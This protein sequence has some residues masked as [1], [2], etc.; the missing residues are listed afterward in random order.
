MK[1]HLPPTLRASILTCM[2]AVAGMF[3]T[4]ATGTAFIGT[5]VLT[6]AVSTAHADWAPA[7]ITYTGTIVVDA[8]AT[9][10][11]TLA[12]NSTLTYT[13]AGNGGPIS[14]PELNIKLIANEAAAGTGTQIN[15]Q[16]N[17][18]TAGS[19]W[20][21]QGRFTVSSATV[22]HAGTLYA[23]GG[24]LFVTGNIGNAIMLGSSTYTENDALSGAA[25][26]IEQGNTVS[27][28]ITLVEDAAITVFSGTASISGAIVTGGYTLEKKGNGLLQFSAQQTRTFDALVLNGGTLRS[29]SNGNNIAVSA[30]SLDVKSN[31]TLAHTN[32][33]SVWTI[34]DLSSSAADSSSIT[35]TLDNQGTHYFRQKF[36]F[37]GTT[38]LDE[39]S[40]FDGTIDVKDTGAKNNGNWQIE[41][42]AG[43]ATQLAH[44]VVNL[45]N[46]AILAVTA[47]SVELEGL[48]S[49][50]TNAYVFSGANGSTAQTNGTN[51]GAT[52]LYTADG[53]IRTLTLS[54]NGD[55]SFTGTI[56]GNLIVNK[57]GGGLQT[58]GN[59]GDNVTIN[60]NAGSL[61]LKGTVGNNTAINTVAG[62]TVTVPWELTNDGNIYTAT[63]HV[64]G[65]VTGDG[66]IFTNV[67]AAVGNTSFSTD[68][69]K[70]TKLVVGD[71]GDESVTI[72]SGLVSLITGNTDSPGTIA[73]FE[74]ISTFILDGGGFILPTSANQEFIF[75]KNIEVRGD[76]YLR[77]WGDG[78]TTALLKLTGDITGSGKLTK[79]DGGTITLAGD[80]SGFTGSVVIG[81]GSLVFDTDAT[82]SSLD[83]N[84]NST[85][86]VIG[87]HRVSVA[88]S[89]DNPLVPKAGTYTFNVEDGSDFSTSRIKFTNATTLN[90][91]SSTH[92]S[93]TVQGM[94]MADTGN[95]VLTI[96]ANTAL[97]VMGTN[98]AKG[99]SGNNFNKNTTFLLAHYSGDSH[100]NVN[101]ALNMLSCGAFGLT[102]RA[103]TM[104]V[105]DGGE[106]N[107]LGL[108]VVRR[109][110]FVAS[111]KKF[112]LTFESGSSLHIGS[113][114]IGNAT[115]DYANSSLVLVF[116]GGTIGILSSTTGWS[117]TRELTL[118]GDVVV[119]TRLYTAATDGTAGSYENTGGT[120]TLTGAVTGDGRLIKKGVGTLNLA[121]VD[122]LDVQ[123]GFVGM[124][125]LLTITDL[126]AMTVGGGR[127]LVDLGTDQIVSASYAGQL[128]LSA[129]ASTAGTF[130]VFSGD[131]NL[132]KDNIDFNIYLDRGLTFDADSG[133]TVNGGQV[134]VTV[135]GTATTERFDLVWAGDAGE[136]WSNSTVQAWTGADDQRF[137][138]GD[139]V[140]F[141]GGGTKE[142]VIE[143][144]VTPGAVTVTGDADYTF[145]GG[146]I[147]GES[148]LTKN[149]TGVLTI[150]TDLSEWTGNID[151]GG[152]TI[153]FAGTLGTGTINVSGTSE[154]AWLKGNATDLS[155]RLKIAANADVTF[156]IA[157]G[158]TVI[159]GSALSPLNTGE[160][161]TFTKA[162]QGTLQLTNNK[163]LYGNVVVAEGTLAIKGGSDP[164]G[165]IA[166]DVTVKSGA[167]ILVERGNFTG[168]YPGTNITK[169]L[170][171]E[172]AEII[173]GANSTANTHSLP[174]N[175][176]TMMGATIRSTVEGNSFELTE[177]SVVTIG[178]TKLSTIE[179][180][181]ILDNGNST[182]GTIFNVADAVAGDGVDLIVKGG[183]S[184]HR[185]NTS[186]TKRGE[187]TME[188][189]GNYAAGKLRLEAGAMIL[190]DGTL[191]DDAL[192]MADGT[193]LQI[194]KGG[195]V[196]WSLNGDRSIDQ[197][198]INLAEGATLRTTSTQKH[199]LTL[200]AGNTL[201]G[202][203]T[204]I[205]GIPTTAGQTDG[206][207]R[208]ITING[209]TAGF[210]GIV[211]LEASEGATG[212]YRGSLTLNSS[213]GIFGGVIRTQGVLYGT[214]TV[215]MSGVV[216][217]MAL[218]TVQK[219]MRIGGFEGTG[220]KLV[221]DVAAGSRVTLTVG[222]ESDHSF[223]GSVGDKIDLVKTG[224]GKQ[225]FDGDLSAFDGSVTVEEGVLDMGSL[226][227]AKSLS[228]TGTG[229]GFATTG[230]VSV[231]A[232]QT[233]A[234]TATGTVVNAHLDIAGGNVHLGD[235]TTESHAVGLGGH[236]LS[237]SATDKTNL[238]LTLPGDLAAGST[239]DLFTDV[240]GLLSGG[241]ALT[242]GADALL[243]TYF[244][245]GDIAA[246][247]N[248]KLQLAGGKL[249]IVLA[250]G[251]N[252]LVYGLGD[253]G[254]WRTDAAFDAQGS[255]FTADA[256]VEFGAIADGDSMTVK[257]GDNISAGSVSIEAGEGKTYRFVQNEEGD[258]LVGSLAAFGGMTIGKGTVDFAADTL[259]PGADATIAVNGGTLSLQ[260]GATNEHVFLRLG[261]G[262]TLRWGSG[263]TT[264]YSA[265][266]RLTI[267]DRAHVT[268]DTNGNR[269]V[270]GVNPGS[271]VNGTT[272]NVTLAG[273]GRLVL[274]D[275][276]VLHGTV[277]LGDQ[278][279]RMNASDAAY[280]LKVTGNGTLIARGKVILTGASDFAGELHIGDNSDADGKNGSEANAANA[281]LTATDT[282]LSAN[283]TAIKLI[284]AADGTGS[285]FNFNAAA[286]ATILAPITGT[287]NV[288]FSGGHEITLEGANSYAGKTSIGADTTLKVTDATLS[289]HTEIGAAGETGGTLE[290]TN[291]QTSAPLEFANKVSESVSVTVSAGTFQWLTDAGHE[292][293]YTGTTTVAANT[294]IAAAGPLTTGAN[295]KIV[296]ADATSTLRLTLT[297]EPDAWT[298]GHTVS[299]AGTLEIATNGA[300]IGAGGTLLQNIID[301][302]DAAGT[303]GVMRLL[304]GTAFEITSSA[305]AQTSVLGKINTIDVQSGA[306]LDMRAPSGAAAQN[307]TIAGA[308]LASAEEGEATASALRLGNGS[309]PTFTLSRTVTL[310]D[311]ATVYVDA[312]KTGV[313][314]ETLTNDGHVLTKTGAGT[315][316]FQKTAADDSYA[317][318]VKA[319]TLQY[320][321]NAGN[322]FGPITLSAGT[323]LS[324][325][326]TANN[327]NRQTIEHLTLDGDATLQ[328]TNFAGAWIVSSLTGSH[329]L[330]IDGASS[331]SENQYAVVNG[332]SFSGVV[333]VKQSQATAN[334]QRGVVF[335]LNSADALQSATIN[336]AEATTANAGILH[337]LVFAVGGD[338]D[339]TI[340]IGALQGIAG[341]EIISS[342][343][344]V[345]D[346]NGTLEDGNART[347]DITG[348]TNQTF[349]GSV[350]ANLTVRMSGTGEQT[351]SGALADGTAFVAQAGALKI[352]SQ[353]QTGSHLFR[354]EGGRLDMSGYARAADAAGT[355]SIVYS[356]GSIDNL[357]LASGMELGAADNFTGSV[358]LGGNTVLD[359]GSL[360]FRL[361]NNAGAYQDL[362]TSY[363]VQSGGSISVG[364]SG[365]TTMLTF[366]PVD[367]KLD[368]TDSAT[369]KDYVLISN[370]GETFGSGTV[371]LDA[372]HLDFNMSTAGR[373]KYTLKV[374]E[375]ADGT[376]DLVLNVFGSA[377]DLT[378]NGSSSA[379]NTA[380]DNA[381]WNNGTADTAFLD[382][383]YV[384]FGTLA[385]A[386]TVTVD[387]AGVRMGGM[388][389]VGSTDYTFEGG[390]ITSSAGNKYATLTIGTVDDE[391]EGTTG[392]E[393]TGTLTI[394]TANSYA[395]GTTI[396]SGTVI[397]GNAA[398]LSNTALVVNGGSLNLNFEGTLGTS[399][400]TMNGGELNALLDASVA[401]LTMAGADTA[402]ALGA[403]A[404]KTL[405]LATANGTIEGALTIGSDTMTGTVR[406]D[407]GTRSLATAQTIDVQGGELLL[408][409]TTGSFNG[410]TVALNGGDLRV[411]GG[412]SATLAG[413]SGTG[414][415]AIVE[416]STLTFSTAADIATQID[417]H[418]ATIAATGNLTLGNLRLVAGTTTL[419]GT[420]AL[421][422]ATETAGT[423]LAVGKTGAAG[424][425]TL[426]AGVTSLDDV[427]I[428][429]GSLTVKNGD[430]LTFLESRGTLTTAADAASLTL[431]SAWLKDGSG[432]DSKIT[433]TFAG[434]DALAGDKAT[435]WLGDTEAGAKTTL[436]DVIVDS[437]S[438][439]NLAGHVELASLRIDRGTVGI[440]SNIAK[441]ENGITLAGTDAALNMRNLNPNATVTLQQGSLSNAGNYAGTV[442]IDDTSTGTA[443][444]MGGLTDKATVTL[445]QFAEGS[446]LTGLGSLKLGDSTIRL[447]DGMQPL[448][449]M[450]DPAAGTVGIADGSTVSI[451]CGAILNDVL[452]NGTGSYTVT[453]GSLGGLVDGTTF[454]NGVVFDPTL[455][456]YN[457]A[458]SIDGGN[459]VFNV[460]DPD[461]NAD[462]VYKSTDDGTA[463]DSYAAMDSIAKVDIDTDTTIDLTG[464]TIPAEQT[465][466]GLIIK[467]LH[468]TGAA[469]TTLAIRGNAD[470][471]VTFNNNL[472]STWYNGSVTVDTA[473]LQIR[474]TDALGDGSDPS[475]RE[476]TIL[477]SLTSTGM[478]TVTDGKLTLAGNGNS[479]DGGLTLN[480]DADA[481]EKGLLTINGHTSLG[482]TVLGGD[483]TTADIAVGNGAVVTLKDGASLQAWISGSNAETLAVAEN[484]QTTFASTARVEGLGLRLDKNATATIRTTG[485]ALSFQGLT[486]TGNLVGDADAQFNLALQ[487]TTT[488]VFGGDLSGYK[489]LITV[490]GEGSQTFTTAAEQTSFAVRGGN[491]TF[492]N[493]DTREDAVHSYGDTTLQ[494]GSLHFDTR[495]AGTDGVLTN[496]TIRLTSLTTVAPIR[497][498]AAGSNTLVFDM[499]LSNDLQGAGSSLVTVTGDNAHI[500]KGTVIDVNIHGIASD[501]AFKPGET[502]SFTLL[503]GLDGNLTDASDLQFKASKSL[504]EKYFGDI[505]LTID[506]NK[507]QLTGTTVTANEV[508]YHQD[509]ATTETGRAGGALLDYLYITA[510]PQG[511]APGSL[512]ASVLDSL[513]DIIDNGGNA[514][515]AMAG[516]A[517][518]T[519]TTLSSA[520]ASGLENQITSI[521]N[522]MT[523]M[524]VD[525]TL[526]N[527]DMPYFHAWISAN[528]G[529]TRL[530]ADG[531]LAG[532]KLNSWGGTV[533]VDVDVNEYLTMGAAFTAS[534]GDLTTDGAESGDGHLDTYTAALFAHARV[535]RWTHDLV[536]AVSTADADLDRT[537][538]YGAGSYK[539][540]GSTNGIGFGA[541]YEAAY[542]I[543]VGEDGSNLLQ[544][545][546]RASF[547]HVSVDGY[548]ETKAE[549]MG[550]AVGKQDITY[551]TFGLGARYIASIGENVFNR[552]AT[553]ELRALA[554]QDAGSRRGEADVALGGATGRVRTVRG[555]KP[556]STGLQA[557]AGLNVPIQETS[558]IFADFSVDVRKKA[559]SVSGSIG[560]R[561]DF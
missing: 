519:V 125:G 317:F 486:G 371:D 151:L 481:G 85:L 188:I 44:T 285:T 281:T 299:G 275:G 451:V 379:W 473:G 434:S 91:T 25:L 510:N 267:D 322:T 277:D 46:Y 279:L 289:A 102:D 262:S 518:S 241:T 339:G 394:N 347:L 118:A 226:N 265:G 312:S 366:I 73:D 36:I 61:V 15:F 208:N 297:G 114:G 80:M 485:D 503:E 345:R 286:N 382:E 223:S 489:G 147:A 331:A 469:E 222:R 149:G 203:G 212:A 98:M 431:G 377:A 430:S 48:T 344:I 84:N 256:N 399:G 169:L 351:L 138:T 171:E 318:A 177:Q 338:A 546:V 242:L 560:Y 480:D 552:T 39:A 82:L 74:S 302:T 427:T 278:E 381:A 538:D 323:T 89:A 557:G 330:T 284:A 357:R 154:L 445:K 442:V 65:Y 181:L 437:A 192:S 209:S 220:G 70:Y 404:D 178:G 390:S 360:S 214:P 2:A 47:D 180:D 218:I 413:L 358:Q 108:D 294:T 384:V 81:K 472:S 53:T 526:V 395:G 520:F 319:G 507:L 200:G 52:P 219:D 55:Y 3:T 175:A 27:G 348:A 86:G 259:L 466:D 251:T 449:V 325:Y 314:A 227:Y 4:V 405:T 287:G 506:G 206:D 113:G 186:L 22:E 250:R 539:T 196:S 131:I 58:L 301:R 460:L 146:A 216:P 54:G 374:T 350:G 527:E 162:G 349:A 190:H 167:K 316:V 369:G 537:V 111:A 238:S 479:L 531:S 363:A 110:D 233:L 499:N 130:V 49:T 389:V 551:A 482:G 329:A 483:G 498:D 291:T 59:I 95:S 76:G 511:T 282:S 99:Q 72:T 296:L 38:T 270:L 174:S 447:A 139:N 101:G 547:T 14:A 92:G 448:F 231:G 150:N 228:L 455:G 274:G 235:I 90:L 400:V 67:I 313:L 532:Y 335:Q 30:A 1:L 164:E 132:S 423:S 376:K 166:G 33:N 373:T 457:V 525:Q 119:D 425:V 417:A 244:N 255:A 327:D 530:D 407:I 116:N 75:D 396:N 310:A 383:D 500:A 364:D 155:S 418:N 68:D 495:A 487:E 32:W 406:F 140:T 273:G 534:Y 64:P 385:D 436:G 122:K 536:L 16:N 225:T 305:A 252:S 63:Y 352:S 443:F 416:N 257:L 412:L 135:G 210:T 337:R 56:A 248:A 106:L 10:A 165:S 380:T 31:S 397:A 283:V 133:L 83:M 555:A 158:D 117:T 303:L 230:K 426:G 153:A 332:G 334:A 245:F 79:T 558:A 401:N 258:A 471:K 105:A 549:S 268:F 148:L 243:S 459:V 7:D 411:A 115:A 528:G 553:L 71:Y 94:Q 191:A 120:I 324:F 96:G 468:N 463:I 365:G 561:I 276:S 128:N 142:I 263:N 524:G 354:A 157:E 247:D 372:Y 542:D 234:I 315:L 35:L 454:K 414:G 361:T 136:V 475:D 239:I 501:F 143:G 159:F 50:N 109:T 213:D 137:S 269:V 217:E 452:R 388:T 326:N 367:K 261:E 104:T 97:N 502:M 195:V 391:T 307:L 152:G 11:L 375:N 295:S 393:F 78:A 402:K 346:K 496:R 272:G 320:Q 336:L 207:G 341:S 23:Q 433:V 5:V 179:A 184:K 306:H 465:Q 478:V 45:S 415:K 450:N 173:L 24:Q 458:A 69:A 408:D 93:V 444:A 211:Q 51:N 545:L 386:Q 491:L 516:I 300:T 205:V 461:H 368:P 198:E 435:S 215:N 107:V 544:P 156:S 221:T 141:D 237:L 145:S 509:A 266:F 124:N 19:V 77:S 476:L 421:N 439:V 533:G 28:R 441:V 37:N 488:A 182:D 41:M 293:T 170:L 18:I 103:A 432:I 550:L 514:D 429:N 34:G 163:S 187:G 232:G 57:T 328:T 112:T 512:A 197:G 467:N 40:L 134:S 477:G 559:T 6:A 522:R 229:A 419:V 290:L 129:N 497:R 246:L 456:L 254:V 172:D 548:T 29:S 62:T 493:A 410:T 160:T 403:V 556:G 87:G 387:E 422:G 321:G 183:F 298:S 304:S 168:W 523:G 189:T 264:D 288:S 127:F 260:A 333:N 529:N 271:G 66:D 253:N 409:G 201:S 513:E 554:L 362:A 490:T 356:A 515:R 224:S 492:R 17:A 249:Q 308:G 505:S 123:E 199:K 470:D 240:S 60:L 378:W 185:G 484:A 353:E 359:G 462:A 236:Q 26:R 311:D 193:L 100:V 392:E 517:G 521:R 474:N 541:L 88:S 543:H 446:S 494:G 9:D 340:S 504:L 370:V 8:A 438:A 43:T 398:A 126:S 464:T 535:K 202:A 12:E 508:H 424:N 309:A 355:D 428:A 453:N 42:H 420:I 13:Y 21:S 121:S 161:A 144:I 292:K 440:Y 194:A 342:S 540:N 176:L 204:L 280:D 20:F 343:G